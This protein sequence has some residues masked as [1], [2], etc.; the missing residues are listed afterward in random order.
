MTRGMMLR[1][2][3]GAFLGVIVARLFFL[4]P[5]QEI[6]FSLF[7]NSLKERGPEKIHWG[8]VMTTQTAAKMWFGTFVGGMVGAVA[9]P[10]VFMD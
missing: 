2:I 6:G 3:A 8:E 4:S 7:W 9:N 1:I 5:V 10:K